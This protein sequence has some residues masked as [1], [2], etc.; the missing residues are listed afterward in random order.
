MPFSAPCR[1]RVLFAKNQVLSVMIWNMWQDAEVG[2]VGAVGTML[3]LVLLGVTLGLRLVGFGRS[4]TI[5][6]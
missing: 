5:K 3:I 6:A 2:E 1:A 4:H